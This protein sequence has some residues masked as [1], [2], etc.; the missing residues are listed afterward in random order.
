MKRV[1]TLGSHTL[2]A[3]TVMFTR[4]VLGPNSRGKRNGEVNRRIRDHLST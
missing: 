4:D 3:V 2:K 1:R